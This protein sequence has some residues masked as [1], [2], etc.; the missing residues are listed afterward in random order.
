ML[1]GHNQLYDCVNLDASFPTLKKVHL[2]LKSKLCDEYLSKMLQSSQCFAQF[3]SFTGILFLTVLFSSYDIIL[4]YLVK[5]SID[6]VF[7]RT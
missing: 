5:N 7:K 3:Q 4:L 2:N 6:H 1:K